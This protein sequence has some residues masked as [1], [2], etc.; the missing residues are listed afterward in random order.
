VLLVVT[1]QFNKRSSYRSEQEWEESVREQLLTVANRDDVK[2]EI[3]ADPKTRPGGGAWKHGGFLQ[4]T[5]VKSGSPFYRLL[6][7]R[8]L[9]NWFT[10]ASIIAINGVDVTEKTPEAT[11]KLWKET[12]TP[13]E[14]KFALDAREWRRYLSDLGSDRKREMR[15]A[16]RRLPATRAHLVGQGRLTLEPSDYVERATVLRGF[17]PLDFDMALNLRPGMILYSVAD[18]IV[19]GEPY[20]KAVSKVYQ[21]QRPVALTFIESPERTL[22]FDQRPSDLVLVNRSGRVLIAGFERMP[23]L[24]QRSSDDIQVGDEIVDLDGRPFPGPFGYNQ[25]LM[26]LRNLRAPATLA[27]GRYEGT[28][29]KQFDVRISED[30]LI[31]AIFGEA[32][33]GRPYIKG[34]EEVPGPGLSHPDLRAGDA[35]LKANDVDV[36]RGF[37]A[38]ETEDLIARS[39]LP[40]QLTVLDV[41]RFDQL[42]RVRD[43]RVP[44]TEAA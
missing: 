1:Q 16:S 2:V 8:R 11:S 9:E 39:E 14:V 13:M 19:L 34:F 41:A 31:G 7:Q 22:S 17:N 25:D 29:Y 4:V 20:E 24:L 36:S 28:Q 35:L 37:S 40:M 23:G 5:E 18:D 26:R 32:A 30:G 12:A 6:Q 33:N 10:H 27:V 21:A 15:R 38:V 43:G 3:V 42:I 44:I